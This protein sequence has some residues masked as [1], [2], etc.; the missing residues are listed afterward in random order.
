MAKELSICFYPC[1]GT[2][3]ELGL[4]PNIIRSGP[5]TTLE[6]P[7]SGLV[8]IL[9]PM[10]RGVQLPPVR[11]SMRESIIAACLTETIVITK[12]DQGERNVSFTKLITD[13]HGVNF[14][15]FD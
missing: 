1:V 10:E 7:G 6:F 2:Q 15:Y 8:V 3:Q 12:L 4:A 11:L 14:L 13:W 5:A 9:T